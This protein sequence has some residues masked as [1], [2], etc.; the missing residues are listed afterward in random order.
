M[1]NEKHQ[2]IIDNSGENNGVI[3]DTINGPVTINQNPPQ[4]TLPSLIPILVE[5]LAKL[6]NL[7]DEE[8]EKTYKITLDQIKEYDIS[9]KIEHN[10][11]IKYKDIIEEYSQYRTIC[12]EAFNIIDNNNLGCKN[13]ILRSINLLYKSYKGELIL[14]NKS[15][16]ASEMDVIRE[17]ADNIIDNIRNELE[18][19]ISGDI[20]GNSIL[21][22]DIEVGLARIICYAF[23]ECKI[24]EKPR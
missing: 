14:K 23:V 1:I 8:I 3:A 10:C 15:S 18:T 24:L 5:Q 19:R 17:N 16:G 12:E 22:E 6:T 9:E 21:V 20:I 7:P 13:K 11:I 2:H 4:K